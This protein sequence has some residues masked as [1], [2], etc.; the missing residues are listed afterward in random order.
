MGPGTALSDMEKSAFLTLLGLKLRQLG[1][2]A[3]SQSLYRL[4]GHDVVYDD[5]IES[6]ETSDESK[7]KTSKMPS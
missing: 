4:L 3:R 5:E 7:N 1:L 2:P 6:T